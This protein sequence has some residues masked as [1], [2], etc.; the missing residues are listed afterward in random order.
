M[1]KNMKCPTC[2]NSISPFKVWLITRWTSIK[3]NKCGAHSSRAFNNLQFWFISALLIIPLAL[4]KSALNLQFLVWMF[5][6]MFID[7]YTITLVPRRREE[8]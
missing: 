2:H 4:L 6:V 8:E 7:A 5:I 1:E 3:C